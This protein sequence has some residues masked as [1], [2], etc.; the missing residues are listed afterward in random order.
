MLVFGDLCSLAMRS[1][2]V[3]TDLMEQLAI[4]VTLVYKSATYPSERG[5]AMD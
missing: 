1:A 4:G 2:F 3:E 5:V